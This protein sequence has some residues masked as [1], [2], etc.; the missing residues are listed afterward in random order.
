MFDHQKLQDPKDTVVEHQMKAMHQLVAWPP[1]QRG[2]LMSAWRISWKRLRAAAYLWM[3]VA[4]P[5]AA[6][7]VYLMEMGWEAEDMDAGIV[8]IENIRPITILSC[9]WRVWAGAYV[10]SPFVQKWLA[11]LPEE[12]VAGKGADAQLA[13]SE[14]FGEMHNYKFGASMDYAKAYDCMSAPATCALL[15]KGGWCPNFCKV[16]LG[17]WGAQRRWVRAGHTGESP[18]LSYSCVPQGC[19]LGPIA[20]CAWMC[21]GFYRVRSQTPIGPT[22]IFMDDR[23]F[24]SQSCDGLLRQIACWEDFSALVGLRESPHKIQL[25]STTS[26]GRKALSSKFVRSER[27]SQE[28]TILGVSA[29]WS[30]RALTSK[31]ADRFAVA[32]ST[33]NLIGSCRLSFS[34]SS[35]VILSHALSKFLYGWVTRLPPMAKVWS[36]WS[37]IRR[38]QGVMMAANRFLRAIVWGGAAHP[39][40]LIGSRLLTMVSK[41]RAKGLPWADCAPCG[42][43]L[44]TLQAWFKSCGCSCVGPW[45]WSAGPVQTVVNL[46]DPLALAS[47]CLRECF[48]LSMWSRFLRSNRHEVAEVSGEPSQRLV[49]SA[50]WKR[51]RELSFQCPAARGVACGAM[52]SPASIGKAGALQFS[53]SCIWPGCSVGFA[54]FSHIAWECSHR[55][56][57]LVRPPNPLDAR[58]GWG[59]SETLTWL[60]EVQKQIWVT[61]HGD[62]ELRTV[63]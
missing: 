18:L 40:C 36:V 21:S 42:S 54:S 9:F 15:E 35:R 16:I 14:L 3:V 56:K 49:M 60:A 41:L 46:D 45:S 34:Q 22:R 48:R 44:G 24:L 26:H 33:I 27:V 53:T 17:V 39:F 19:P 11:S 4:G 5:M 58:F 55:S 12:I 6:L 32:L 37:A 31:E 20:M 10:K 13:A 38:V 63:N 57:I 59:S 43:L 23:S 50:D 62:P 30:R 7:Q 28:F 8:G 25:T 1:A 51:I 29:A 61:R 52:L 47:H 2:E